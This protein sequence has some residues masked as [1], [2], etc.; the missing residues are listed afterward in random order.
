MRPRRLR[1]AVMLGLLVGLG[2]A[3]AS[4]P[5]RGDRE[6]PAPENASDGTTVTSAEMERAGEP[7]ETALIG[8]VSGAW[9]IRTPDGGIAVRLRGASTI[10]GSTEPL[11]VIDGIPIEPGPNGSLVG[12]NPNDIA[13]IQVLTDAA[14]LSLYGVR[15]SN[16]VI[17]IT[18]KRPSQ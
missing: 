3:C 2:V 9:L 16:G 6:A 17:L 12:I 14:S 7:L 8:R 5:K 13:R 1:A 18:T 10:E 4:G 15:G 11:Y